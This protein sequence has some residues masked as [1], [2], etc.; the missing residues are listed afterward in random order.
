MFGIRN[1]I[2]LLVLFG[3]MHI[4]AQVSFNYI[5]V[6]RENVNKSALKSEFQKRLDVEKGVS[7]PKYKKEF[8]QSSSD[9]FHGMMDAVDSNFFYLDDTLNVYFQN[10]LK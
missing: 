1:S 9:L 3:S 10:I 4:S 5:P 8:V 7:Y 6:T 2:F